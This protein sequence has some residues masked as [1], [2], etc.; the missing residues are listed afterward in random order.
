[1]RTYGLYRAEIRSLRSVLLP[2]A[3]YEELSCSCRHLDSERYGAIYGRYITSTAQLE[4]AAVGE[5]LT[6]GLPYE[7]DVSLHALLT[8]AEHNQAARLIG[9][10]HTHGLFE[11]TPSVTD[12]EFI[13]LTPFIALIAGTV[14]QTSVVRGFKPR[15][16]WTEEVDILI[17]P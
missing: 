15:F 6:S 17:V 13:C 11:P 7:C 1:M 2:Q 4:V 9:V 8:E 5:A 16:S 3:L 14:R 12:S 10:Y